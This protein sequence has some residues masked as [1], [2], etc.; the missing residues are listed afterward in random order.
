MGVPPGGN[1]L[2]AALSAG[3]WRDMAAAAGAAVER[4]M[5]L[6]RGSSLRP[7][8]SGVL[9]CG[10]LISS[11]CCGVLRPCCNFHNSEEGGK[12]ASSG[13]NRTSVAGRQ[14]P[15][16]GSENCFYLEPTFRVCACALVIL[17]LLPNS[18]GA[19]VFSFAI[20]WPSPSLFW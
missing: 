17:P 9:E 10:L 15:A 12:E 20:F 19:V 14:C 11:D 7:G 1:G 18:A 8:S 3:P 2:C 6:S 16:R 5:G 4:S 13:P